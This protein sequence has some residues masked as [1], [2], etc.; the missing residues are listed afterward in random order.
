MAQNGRQKI[1]ITGATR[2][3]GRALFARFRELGQTV[4]GCGSNPES[5]RR[6]AGEL[7]AEATLSVVDVSDAQ[8]VARWAD[9][10]IAAV[11]APDLLINNAGVINRNAPLWEI[12]EIEFNRVIDVNVKGAA[13]VIR[14]FLPAMLQRKTGVIANISS[15][16]GRSASGEVAPYCA[17]KWAI[18]GLTLALSEE[19]PPEL[20]AVS[21]NPGIIN[22]DMLRSSFGSGADSYPSP[23]DWVAKA[24][25]FLLSIGAKDNGKQL[26]V[27]SSP[28]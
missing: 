20:A 21:I 25:P 6:L 12:S 28:V 10:V 5:V 1:V 27:S 8:N 14:S 7:G 4:I 22:T 23:A 15:G 18:E 17:S 24:A 9:S 16:W 11:G 13:N 2:G 26:S 3:L 19:L